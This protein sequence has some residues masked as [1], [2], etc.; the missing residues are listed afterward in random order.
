MPMDGEVRGERAGRFADG[1]RAVCLIAATYVYFL[2]FAQFGF[3]KRLAQAGI[4]DADLKPVMAAMAAGGIIA[5]LMAA[6]AG[7][8]TAPR[9]LRLAL[10]GC[11]ANAGLSLLHVTRLGFAAIALMI[12]A[13]LGA[14]TVTLVA[15]LGLW[16]GRRG[17]LLRVGIGTG[18]GYWICN[19]PAIFTASPTTVALA[20]AGA[21]GLGLVAASRSEGDASFVAAVGERAP[22]PFP[23]V[24]VWLTTLVWFDSAAFFIL[25]NSPAIEAG[26]WTGAAHL[27]RTG[28]IHFAAALLSVW[29]VARRG[30][31]AALLSAFACLASACL[32]LLQPGAHGAAAWLYPAGVSLYSVV[33]VAYAALLIRDASA[34]ERARR[35]GWLYAIA[36]WIGSAMGIGMAQHLH[37]VPVWF[38][39]TAAVLFV[40][41]LVRMAGR[42]HWREILA[43]AAVLGAAW[44]LEHLMGGGPRSGEEAQTAVE[45][46]R[47]V[48]IAEG[49]IN[50]HSQYVRPH[51]R[52]VEIWG[53]AEDVEAIRREHPPL[54]GNRREGPD[55]SQVGARRSPLW[56]RIHLI[57]PRATSPGSA[58][59]SY[60]YLFGDR[61][62]SDLVAYLS[63]LQSP[64]AMQHIRREAAEWNPEVTGA[65]GDS[66]EGARLFEEYCASCHNAEGAIRRRWGAK[67]RKPS[68]E[69]DAETINKIAAGKSDA[70]LQ[71]QLAR[72]IRFG[73]PGT[74]MPGHETMPATQVKA[75][76]DWL[77]AKRT[78]N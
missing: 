63:S 16:M 39:G 76:A 66:G 61:R 7:G 65:A 48:Y 59:P 74:D 6:R 68:P 20:G 8:A 37:R 15:N 69:L 60:A 52:D 22:L 32:L 73:I 51:S 36:G 31:A 57:D 28:A 58:M 55:L 77:A 54:I 50:C 23:V 43:V 42:E 9:R 72:T 21:C 2:I 24:L 38:I 40:A 47:R 25:Q 33:L 29:M 13:S 11:A 35:A 44:G 75:I 5:S 78:Q 67:F 41:P 70:Q 64:G 45:R 30:A 14:L 53:P 56:L 19:I 3:L 4:A 27:W 34:G 62:G 12:G 71:V 49:C 26:A 1:W 10:V 46:G 18:L 17:P